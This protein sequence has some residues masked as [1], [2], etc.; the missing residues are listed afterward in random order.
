MSCSH[1]KLDST[2]SV[3][4]QQNALPDRT[5]KMLALKKKRKKTARV[6]F[7]KLTAFCTVVSF[8]CL[9]AFCT[10]A[11]LAH[12]YKTLK[13]LEKGGK[14]GFFFLPGVKLQ[15]LRKLR[16]VVL[17]VLLLLLLM[18]CKLVSCWSDDNF[19]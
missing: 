14:K 10:Q 13:P 7:C 17:L 12:G 8:I 5:L 9:E 15:G 18:W 19:C 4:N 1:I 16:V 3:V 11:M 2:I 6:L